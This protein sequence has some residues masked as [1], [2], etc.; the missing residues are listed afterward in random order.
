MTGRR[1]RAAVVLAGLCLAVGAAACGNAGEAHPP[2]GHASGGV[3]IGLLLPDYTSRFE[4]FD[5]PLIERKVHQLCPTCT[6]EF[7]SAQHDVATQQQ[8]VDAMITK[9]VQVMILDAVDSRSLRSSVENARRAGIQVVAYDRLAEGPVSGY[10][11]F[12]GARVGRLQGAALLT[13]L[14]GKAHGGRIVMMNG[15]PTDPNSAWFKGGALA[16]LHGKVRIGA[17]Y[18]TAGWRP[19]NAN[20]NMSGAISALGADRIDG[21]YAANDGLAGGVIAAMKAAKIS[22]LPPVTGQDAELAA[23]QRILRG[24]QLMSVYKPFAP[25]AATAAAMAV[26]LGHGRSLDGITDQ[27]VDSPTTHGI[28]AVLLDPVA[29]N[30]HTIKSTVVKDGMYTIDQICTPKFAAACARA[31]LTG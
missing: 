19:E 22:P 12:D 6:V 16:V 25:E 7:A 30:V 20:A 17:S 1:R 5:R 18:E 10:V 27:K 23:V 15:A 21:V 11:T 13:A 14:G 31:G 3:K 24:E 26:A 2:G 4:K 9:R 8:Q 29:L 28:P